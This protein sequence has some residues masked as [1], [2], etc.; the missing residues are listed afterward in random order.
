VKPIG[1]WLL[2]RLIWATGVE[3]E[4][5]KQVVD[6]LEGCGEVDNDEDEEED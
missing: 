4:G 5:M 6:A 2:R 1:R 3:F